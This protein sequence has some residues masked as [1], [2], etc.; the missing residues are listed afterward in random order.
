MGLTTL[1]VPC[2]PK[3][4][5]LN[6][7]MWERELDLPPHGSE[8]NI[9]PFGRLSSIPSFGFSGFPQFHGQ[10]PTSTLQAW[11]DGRF[12]MPFWTAQYRTF[13]H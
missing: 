3:I 1:Q 10:V 6:V 8:T 9:G 7:Y 2:P 13:H 11:S 5:T 12:A 4:A